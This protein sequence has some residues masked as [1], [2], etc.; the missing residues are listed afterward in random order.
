MAI[1]IAP[2]PISSARRL[3]VIVAPST[4]APAPIRVNTTVKPSTNAAVEVTTRRVCCSSSP[5]VTPER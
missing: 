1:T 2:A 4:P 5:N 3:L